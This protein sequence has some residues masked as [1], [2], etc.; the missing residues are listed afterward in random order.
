MS[1]F[2]AGFTGCCPR[3]GKGRIFADLLELKDACPACGL[4]IKEH[5]NGDGP[6]FFAIV[7]VG[8]LVTAAAGLVEYAYAPPYW[9]H[10][11]LWIPL[12][13]TLSLF[14]LRF[15]KGFL[16]ASQLKHKLLGNDS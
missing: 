7:L 3:C 4:N 14:L 8:M 11:L 5:D 9:L 6:I 15:F 13:L 1:P 12:I 2:K 10:A 16:L